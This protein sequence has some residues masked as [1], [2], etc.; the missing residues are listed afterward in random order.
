M[1]PRA[2]RRVLAATDLSEGAQRA[3]ERAA[4][5][6]RDHGAA[7]A[8]LHVV[9]PEVDDLALGRGRELVDGLVASLDLAPETLVR[10][11]R[12]FEE[13]VRSARELDVDLVVL[14]ASGG[15]T[16]REHVL[17][18][19][20][21]R[22]V[23]HGDRPV[24]VVRKPATGVEYAR[25]LAGVDLSEPSAAAL[26]FARAAFARAELQVVHV[27]IVVGEHR[28]R[29]NGADDE[30][31]AQLRAR[32]MDSASVEVDR[33]L[34]EQSLPTEAVRVEPGHPPAVL[35]HL[36]DAGRHEGL[37]VVGAHGSTGPRRLLLGSV[38]Q[39][40]LR[41]ARCDVLVVRHGT[42]RPDPPA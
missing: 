28:L 8:V 14:G 25:V 26:E 21:E 9:D 19:T 2:F 13:I 35:A 41:D 23:R 40:I 36:A 33:W 18:T 24:L 27:R 22:V 6:A 7:L 32:A 10:S 39:R 5:I 20:S 42:S 15:D 11:G 4:V 3:L 29:M 37:V 30:A 12:P 1:S 34:S 17:G 16:V 38:S 31:I